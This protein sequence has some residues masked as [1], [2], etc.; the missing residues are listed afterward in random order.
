M[1]LVNK[2]IV[3]APNGERLLADITGQESIPLSGSLY[4]KLVTIRDWF[5]SGNINASTLQNLTKDNFAIVDI[6]S[7]TSLRNIIIP[8]LYRLSGQLEGPSGCEYGLMLVICGSQLISQLVMGSRTN[9]MYWR[10]GSPVEVGGTEDYSEWR[11]IYHSS[12]LQ[13][14]SNKVKSTVGDIAGYLEA[15]L[16][17]G[18]SMGL[19]NKIALDF[20]KVLKNEGFNSSMLKIPV[21][22]IKNKELDIRLPYTNYEGNPYGVGTPLLVTNVAGNVITVSNVPYVEYLFNDIQTINWWNMIAMNKHAGEA[23]SILGFTNTGA[24]TS[25]SAVTAATYG[26]ATS[27]FTVLNGAVFTIG[28]TIAL[29]S[30]RNKYFKFY[31]DLVYNRLSGGK[32]AGVYAVMKKNDGNYTVVAGDIGDTSGSRLGIYTT[33]KLAKNYTQMTDT[34]TQAIFNSADAGFDTSPWSYVAG[35]PTFSADLNC[36]LQVAWGFVGGVKT[37]KLCVI[38]KGF[39]SIKYYT[40]NIEYSK[41]RSGAN[42]S[43]MVGYS[44]ITYHAGIYY[45]I[46]TEQSTTYKTPAESWIN[47]CYTSK[48]IGGKFKYHSTPTRGCNFRNDGIPSSSHNTNGWL[49]T[50]NGRLYYWVTVTGRARLAGNKAKICTI[51]HILNEELSEWEILPTS[52]ILNPRYTGTTSPWGYGTADAWAKDHIGSFGGAL[53]EDSKMK[54]FIGANNGTDTYQGGYAEIRLYDSSPDFTIF[55]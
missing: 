39:E 29:H 21:Q 46:V 19:D 55:G 54:L 50:F 43:L 22:F 34:G 37:H 1:T 47:T 24:Y 5:L 4:S 25:E 18:L 15:K 53:F 10:S 20:S 49:F 17:D 8:G 16:G 31:P 7:T 40:L 3:E 35:Q 27:T 6:Y 51:I 23:D 36:W 26:A 33:D 32:Y 12:S 52:M 38:S 48:T 13:P 9:K 11:E 2:K 45:L 14:E 41:I 28:D 42:D 30:A 44:V